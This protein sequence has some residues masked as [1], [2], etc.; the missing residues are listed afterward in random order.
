MTDPK[1]T[2]TTG[3]QTALMAYI[4]SNAGRTLTVDELM[5]AKAGISRGQVASSMSHIIER[6]HLPGLRRMTGKGTYR[7]DPQTRSAPQPPRVVAKKDDDLMLLKVAYTIPGDP[8]T[9]I[10]VDDDSRAVYKLERIA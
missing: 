5:E 6:G 10:A 1:R 9:V 3:I 4:S 2:R 7:F 8:P